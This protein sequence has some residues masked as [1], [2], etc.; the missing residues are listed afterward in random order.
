MRREQGT[1]LLLFWKKLPSEKGM[2]IRVGR[3]VDGGRHRSLLPTTQTISFS[4]PELSSL[5]PEKSWI[6]SGRKRLFQSHTHPQ[7]VF[8]L[9]RKLPT[10]H[11]YLL[12]WTWHLT[13][14]HK[15]TGKPIHR[16]SPYSIYADMNLNIKT[17]PRSP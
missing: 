11:I 15:H 3:L 1:K 13:N 8:A 12:P 9:S 14:R 17:T 5:F 16:L 4:Q 6:T 7:K 10:L 2:R